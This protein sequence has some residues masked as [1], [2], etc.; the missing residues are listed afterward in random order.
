MQHIPNYCIAQSVCNSC[1]NLPMEQHSKCNS[2]G[3][4][5]LVCSKINSKTKSYEREPCPQTCGYREVVF[6]GDDTAQEFSAWLCSPAHE[7]YTV[8]S[9][10]G[11]SYDMPFVLNLLLNKTHSKVSC[12]YTGGKILC[13]RIP[14]YNINLIDSISF[15]PMALAKIPK[16]FGLST[17]KG[18]FPHL[19]NTVENWN[20]VG[21][22]PSLSFYDVDS[23][24]SSARETFLLWY[25]TLPPETMFD[26]QK[27]MYAY[28]R[29]DV[30]ILRLCCTAFRNMVL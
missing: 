22:M 7:D 10:N 29:K 9:H 18:T 14:E 20:Y 27:E 1:V 26:F 19:F 30:N 4:R 23:M 12:I 21:P 3:T 2:C 15:M 11:K 24:S 13:L 25:L 8:L 28:C 16:C 6:K 17:S 5:C